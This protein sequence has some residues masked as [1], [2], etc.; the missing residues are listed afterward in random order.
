MRNKKWMISNDLDDLVHR[1]DCVVNPVA[2][3]WFVQRGITVGRNHVHW[4]VDIPGDARI[5]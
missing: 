1:F 4:F 5:G 3:V 2:C